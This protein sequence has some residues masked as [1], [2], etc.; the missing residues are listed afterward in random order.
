[1]TGAH[2][3]DRDELEKYAE[4]LEQ[5]IEILGKENAALAM[6]LNKL[7]RENMKLKSENKVLERRLASMNTHSEV[8]LNADAQ[9]E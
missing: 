8:S 6:T 5:R 7:M 4:K 3:L 2:S 9:K 1:M